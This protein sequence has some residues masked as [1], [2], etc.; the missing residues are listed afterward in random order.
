MLLALSQLPLILSKWDE[1]G[2]SRLAPLHFP[3]GAT[4]A[5]CGRWGRRDRVVLTAEMAI[6]DDAVSGSETFRLT[7]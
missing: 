5:A 1:V 7:E 4:L 6:Q 2:N 3:M